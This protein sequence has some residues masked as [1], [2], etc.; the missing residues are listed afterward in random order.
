MKYLI[1]ICI[2]QKYLKNYCTWLSG[3]KTQPQQLSFRILVATWCIMALVLVNAYSS[4]LISYLSV[5]KLQP[6]VNS[7]EELAAQNSLRLIVPAKTIMANRILVSCSN[8]LKTDLFQSLYVPESLCLPHNVPEP[9][10]IM[11]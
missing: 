5:P 4:T 8:F 10:S 3:N 1:C 2:S 9:R 7:L 11:R 6:I